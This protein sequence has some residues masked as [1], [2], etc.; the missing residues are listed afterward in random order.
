MNYIIKNNNQYLS[1]NNQ[2]QFILV[3]DEKKALKMKKNKATKILPN[4]PRRWKNYHLKIIACPEKM[5]DKQQ[6]LE[7]QNHELTKLIKYENIDYI[8]SEIDE[9]ISSCGETSIKIKHMLETLNINLSNTD[10]AVI[11][12]EHR[13]EFS[14]KVNAC[15]GWYYF[16][17]LREVLQQRR[18][19]KDDIFYLKSVLNTSIQEYGDGTLDKILQGMEHRKYTSRILGEDF[20]VN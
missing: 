3:S 7:K 13:I 1:R 5:K 18:K 4:L 17:M 20:N 6:C 8:R 9:M 19:I 12:L 10:K 15:E 2:G 11:D 16:S 14:E